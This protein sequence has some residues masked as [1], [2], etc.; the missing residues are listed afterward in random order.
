MKGSKQRELLD[1]TF[2]IRRTNNNKATK[3]FNVTQ[4]QSKVL[5]DIDTVKASLHELQYFIVI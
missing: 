1:W 5:K 2:N 4:L 3:F